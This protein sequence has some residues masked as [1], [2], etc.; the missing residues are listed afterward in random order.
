MGTY[1]YR[2][3][4]QASTAL[5]EIFDSKLFENP[6]DHGVLGRFCKYVSTSKDDIFLDFFSG[7]CST[8][9][10]ILDLNK[11]DGGNRKFIM[12]QLPEPCDEKSE[13]FKAGYQTIADIGKERIRRVIQKIEK[14]QEGQL[15]LDA[16]SKKQDLGF[17]VFK[18]AESN[19]NIWE[20]D[21]TDPE[22]L[23]EQLEMHINHLDP[24][25][26]AEDIFYELLLKAGFPLTTEVA[27][28]SISG[29]SAYSIA[30]GALIICLDTDLTKEAIRAIADLKPVQCIC[31]DAAFHE[32]DQLK[33]NA[34]QTMEGAKVQFRTV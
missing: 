14:E 25:A 24:K 15:D 13:A 34:V 23:E 11:E 17:K 5:Q 32:N 22:K 4:L 6:K 28:I 18:L 30:E 16:G 2:S 29:K 19:F 31:L 7:S 21:E 20:G 27:Q 8:A 12:V 3:A 10:G 1:F 26:T 9:Q 33:T